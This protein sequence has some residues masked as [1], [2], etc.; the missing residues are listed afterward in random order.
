MPAWDFVTV[1]NGNEADV[2][3]EGGV[4]EGGGN[5]GFGS[6]WSEDDDAALAKL[7]LQA[8][9]DGVDRQAHFEVILAARALMRQIAQRRKK[10]QD[11]EPG[12]A[13]VE[14]YKRQAKLLL[15]RA[16]QVPVGPDSLSPLCVALADYAASGNSFYTMRG[17]AAWVV[18]GKVTELLSQQDRLQRG[19][20]ATQAWA[21]CV[22]ALGVAAR[23]LR[24]IQGL[25]LE[26]ARKLSGAVAVTP[27]S[28]RQVLKKAQEGWR[29]TYFEVTARS[30][31]YRHGALLQGLCGMR[32]LE[33]E[34]GVTVRRRGVMVA[35]KIL[36]AKVRKSAGQEWRGMFIPAERFPDWFLQDLGSEPKTY[37]APRGAMRSYLKRLSPLVFPVEGNQPQLI[38]SAYVLRHSIATDLRQAGWD[39]TEIAQVFGERRAETSRWYG[40]R[41][42]G[43][44]FRRRPQ[45]AIERG[46]VETARPVVQRESDFLARK[47]EAKA[48]KKK[49]ATPSNR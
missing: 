20:G 37:S 4:D 14:K 28:K 17:A 24:D 2:E 44:K 32:P 19:S 8:S 31:K 30:R 9:A 1:A 5:E 47:K 27:K 41:W 7:A 18:Q 11:T 29:D 12:I 43:S 23:L 39:S 25:S 35:V 48:G 34:R 36:G 40:L 42:R 33:L 26:G 45:I 6:E 22:A 16:Q 46:T 21:D 10:R 15:R 13:T 38:L 49:S 3:N